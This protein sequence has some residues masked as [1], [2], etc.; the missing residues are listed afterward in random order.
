MIWLIHCGR[1]CDC[2]NMKLQPITD[3]VMV[4]LARQTSEPIKRDEDFPE[5]AEV[6]NS[7][8]YNQ[9]VRVLT[10]DASLTIIYKGCPVRRP[11][12]GSA[13]AALH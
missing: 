6:K 5:N 2:E 4:A 9:C 11:A 10:A 13:N 1:H 7:M 8:A 3:I 12:R